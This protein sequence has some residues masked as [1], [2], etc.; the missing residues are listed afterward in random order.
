MLG[1]TFPKECIYTYEDDSCKKPLA[2]S[3]KRIFKGIFYGTFLSACLWLGI[4]ALI[5]SML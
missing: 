5:H 2:D 4:G 3:K 1:L